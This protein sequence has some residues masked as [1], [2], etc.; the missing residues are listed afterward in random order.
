MSKDRTRP[1]ER[2][3]KRAEYGLVFIT[4]AA[5]KG[6]SDAVATKRNVIVDVWDRLTTDP[7]REDGVLV[8]R[9]QGAELGLGVYQGTTYD[10]YQIKFAGGGR[11][12]YFVR[13]TSEKSAR[14]AGHVLIEQV[15]THHPNQTK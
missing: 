8:Y 12:W 14:L 5:E 9:L 4:R 6:W 15:H 2:P 1:I 7:T 10:R 3:L 13:P 11:I